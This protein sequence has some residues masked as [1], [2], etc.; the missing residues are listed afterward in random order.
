MEYD[1]NSGRDGYHIRSLY[2]D[3]LYDSAIK[4]KLS[5]VQFRQKY[6]VRIYNKQD[7]VIKLERKEKYRDNIA[8][9]SFKLT[10]EQFYKIIGN[11]DIEFLLHEGN[12]MTEQMYWNIRTKGLAPAVIVD[13]LRQVFVCDEGNVRIT[14][15][16][17]LEAGID[18]SDVFDPEVSIVRAFP[19]NALI[20]E[21]KYDDYIPKHIFNA[22]QIQSHK[23]EALSKYVI[24][25]MTQLNWNP[26]GK[27]LRKER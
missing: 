19:P 9:Q 18:T 10:K 14:F 25:R 23:K 6:R 2:F 20:L 16:M 15:D 27:V 13:Y 17:N 3:D 24:C 5:G 21:V 7:S 4:D 22:L 11:E 12:N 1:K 26:A 8:K